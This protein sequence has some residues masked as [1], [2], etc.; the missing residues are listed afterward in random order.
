MATFLALI[1]SSEF[2]FSCVLLSAC[3]LEL[4]FTLGGDSVRLG[5][6][7]A[8]RG[9][10]FPGYNQQKGDLELHLQEPLCLGSWPSIHATHFSLTSFE[11]IFCRTSINNSISLLSVSPKVTETP[12]KAA[13]KKLQLPLN[14]PVSIAAHWS[15]YLKLFRQDATV[16]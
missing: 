6:L 12:N 3:Y 2:P 8:E 9:G 14:L 11:F 5:D 16:V 1:P 15:K 7:C 4:L 13:R 10:A